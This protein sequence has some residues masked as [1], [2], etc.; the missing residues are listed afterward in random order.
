MKKL[1][2]IL[3]HFISLTDT[4]GGAV[5]QH[6]EFDSHHHQI[7]MRTYFLMGHKL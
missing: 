7:L 5:T 4:T 3:S 6:R 1:L 2:K